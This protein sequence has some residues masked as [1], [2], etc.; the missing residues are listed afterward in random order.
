MMSFFEEKIHNLKTNVHE[1]LK[2]EY[3]GKSVSLQTVDFSNET[4]E[5]LTKWRNKNWDGFNT[6]FNAKFDTTKTWLEKIIFDKQ[7]ILF[8]IIY[9]GEKIGNMGIAC[10]DES[11]D[12]I[13]MENFIKGKSNVAPGIM[14]YVEKF[15]LKWIFDEFNN[16]KIKFYVFSDNFKTIRLHEK[17]GFLT[18]GTIPLKREFFKDGWKWIPTKLSSTEE[19]GERYFLLMC[20]ENLEK[21]FTL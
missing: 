7:Q 21:R 9:D 20:K 3:L 11:D 8:L 6:K 12:C 13:W 18:L 17:C 19:Y 14:E 5:L 2:L 1:I 10:Y 16:S 15:F 4:I